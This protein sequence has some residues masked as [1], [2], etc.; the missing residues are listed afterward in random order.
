MPYNTRRKSL[1]LPSLGIQLPHGSRAIPQTPPLSAKEQHTSKKAKRSHSPLSIV[2]NAHEPTPPLSPPPERVIDYED[3][4]DEIVCAVVRTLERTGNRPHTVKE[5]AVVL[6]PNINT[7]EHSANPHAIISARLNSYLK[8][9]FSRSSPAVL[10]K[11]LITT[12]PRRIY[13]YLTTQP[14]QPI[15]EHEGDIVIPRRGVASPALSDEEEDDLRRR[16]EMSP[17]PE[18]DLSSH[19]LDDGDDVGSD[20]GSTLSSTS[21]LDRARTRSPSMLHERAPAHG[22]ALEGDEK[23]FSQSAIYMSRRTRHRSAEKKEHKGP[24]R[25]RTEY[26][27]DNEH[28]HGDERLYEEAATSLVSFAAANGPDTTP[29]TPT[30]SEIPGPQTHVEPIHTPSENLDAELLSW[31]GEFER[32]LG[33]PESV[34]LD[35]LDNLLDF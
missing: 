17:S 19:E 18:V 6:A 30:K 13:F 15:P 22:L 33:S 4:N 27:T 34:D 26:E 20:T 11:E 3:I 8:R 35:E 5:L 21:I 1:S 14:H 25:S 9:G 29:A 7:V 12:H 23:E 28:E 24:K 10:K 31:N 2:Q 32:H 16:S